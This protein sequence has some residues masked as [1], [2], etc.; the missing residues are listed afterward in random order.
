MPADLKRQKK[1]QISNLIWYLKKLVKEQLTKP[2]VS[3]RKKIIMFGTE[4][5]TIE[6]KTIQRSMNPRT[7]S[8]RS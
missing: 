8:L 4:I 3:K 5:N 2:K 1:S 7:V 6:S